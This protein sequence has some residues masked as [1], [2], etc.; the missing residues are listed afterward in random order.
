MIEDAFEVPARKIEPHVQ[1][2]FQTDQLIEPVANN[3]A[4]TSAGLTDAFDNGVSDIPNPL[5]TSMPDIEEFDLGDLEND[6]ELELAKLQ[7]DEFASEQN[8]MLNDDVHAIQSNVVDDPKLSAF[9]PTFEHN[10]E[11]A[12]APSVENHFAQDAKACRFKTLKPMMPEQSLTLISN[13]KE[14]FLSCYQM[15]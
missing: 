11:A 1:S 5:S 3:I 14:N 13:W 4:E 12:Y 10:S 6:L 7:N 8:N 15:M 9:E 2:D